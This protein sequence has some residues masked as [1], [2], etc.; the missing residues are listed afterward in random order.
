MSKFIRK[1]LEKIYR[2]QDL[3][4]NRDNY[5][6]LDKNENLDELEPFILNKLKQLNFSKKIKM[7]PS[8]REIYELISKEFKINSKNLLLTHGSDLA[9]KTIYETYTSRGEKVMLQKP[10]YAMTN[11]YAKLFD[12]KIKFFKI[13]KDFK[14][15][16]NNFYKTLSANKIKIIFV[17]SP[18][19]FTGQEVE[20]KEILKLLEYTTKKKILLVIDEAYFGFSK[21]SYEKLISKYKNLILTR[22]LSKAYGLA[23]LR[24]GFLISNI[25]RIQELIKFKPLHEIS[26]ISAE[27]ARISILKNKRKNFYNKNFELMKYIKKISNKF[28]FK[29]KETCTNFFLLKYEKKKQLKLITELKKKK[30]LIRRP[31]NLKYLDNYIRITI[32]NKKNIDILFKNLKIINNRL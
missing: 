27:I 4:F 8:L 19:G 24:I 1:H 32:T 21:N 22:T 28:G 6:A 20:K 2:S 11:V 13:K 23:G 10:S 18:N 12:V 30:I 16:F 29:I 14:I 25:E 26:N 3:D 7:Y 31:Y 15:D 17:E 5:L 9:I